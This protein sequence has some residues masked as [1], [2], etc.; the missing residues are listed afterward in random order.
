MSNLVTVIKADTIEALK[1]KETAKL[2]T[3]RLLVA[4]FEK[5]KVANKLADVS[6]LSNEQ[7]QAVISRQVKKL[8]KE[9]E[10]YVEVGRETSSQEAEKELLVSY[11]PK[12]LSEEELIAVVK[13][14][15]LKTKESGH[16]IGMAMKELSARLKG[17]ADMSKVS[18]LAREQFNN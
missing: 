9:I 4:E 2:S 7:A 5:E 15:A 8:D 13:E 18:K 1:N 12:Q 11:L 16:N 14:I 3:L 6:D 17:K 10:A